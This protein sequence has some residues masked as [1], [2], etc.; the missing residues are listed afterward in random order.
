M[1]NS[2]SQ[3]REPIDD[4]GHQ[5]CSEGYSDHS[6]YRGLLTQL[7]VLPVGIGL[8]VLLKCVISSRPGSKT[9]FSNSS[10][11]PR[12]VGTSTTRGVSGL[13]S[14]RATLPPRQCLT[15]RYADGE[16]AP[17]LIRLTSHIRETRRDVDLPRTGG[18]PRC[19]REPTWREPR[20][21]KQA[22]GNG[23][24]RRQRRSFTPEFKAE[25]IAA[26][27]LRCI[28][29]SAASTS[30]SDDARQVL[31]RMHR[32]DNR[33][34]PVTPCRRGSRRLPSW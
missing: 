3:A 25:V 32:G 7:F 16:S 31:S 19:G 4:T 6:A 18:H 27:P 26:V 29:R 20:W 28:G 8:R 23:A 5:C 34:L 12:S 13:A 9:R 17:S 21:G 10:R 22:E 15:S 30:P 14:P 11:L 1:P 24:R 33:L 2:S